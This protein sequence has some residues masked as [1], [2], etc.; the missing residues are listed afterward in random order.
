VLF[1]LAFSL[2][3]IY[4]IIYVERS[5]R[6]IPIQYPRRM[7]GKRMTQAQTQYLPLKVNMAGVIP[8]IFA[9][10]IMMLPAT[11]LTVLPQANFSVFSKLFTPGEWGYEAIYVGLIVLFSYFYTAVIFNPTEVADNLK[12]NGGFIPLVRPGQE[13]ADYL[14][15]VLNRLTLWGAAYISIICVVPQLVYF[16]M[17]ASAFGY[18][19]GGTA[20][21]IVVGVTLDTAAQIES[22][23][24]ARNYEAFMSRSSKEQSALGMVGYNRSRLVRR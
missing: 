17:G 22:M 20:V 23:R 24:V 12:K 4:S 7:V 15:G 6:K 19:F 9:S 13:T 2:L 16:N 21:L 5:H 1:L 11:I 8:P 18:V 10:A 14:Y 3:T